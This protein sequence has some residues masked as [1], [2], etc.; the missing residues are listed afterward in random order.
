MTSRGW[1]PVVGAALLGAILGWWFGRQSSDRPGYE[2]IAGAEGGSAS[3][4]IAALTRRTQDLEK[5]LEAALSAASPVPHLAVAPTQDG[6]PGPQEAPPGRPKKLEEKQSEGVTVREVAPGFWVRV[7]QGAGAPLALE[8]FQ[9]A[10]KEP[11]EPAPSPGEVERMLDSRDDAERE[12]GYLALV[13]TNDK[14]YLP[15]LTRRVN[16][17]DLAPG[18][19]GDLMRSIARV[20]D[21]PWSAEQ[22]TGAPDTP[23][24][25]DNP[26]AWAS[27]REDMGE[28]TLELEFGTAVRVDA[29]RI[30]ETFN[31]GAVARVLAQ[32]PDGTWE[33]IWSGFAPV[34]D[35]PTWFDPSVAGTSYR[36]SRIR[37][38][39]DT[40]RVKGWNEIDAVELVGDGSRQ[41]VK[42][43]SASSSYAEP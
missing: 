34:V 12:K 6:E 7:G 18:K 2:G 29:V 43:A 30:H 9:P 19:A 13:T 42:A 10:T 17:P 21:R 25:G 28:V 35:A 11:Q 15:L 24:G 31:P 23:I 32:T 4:E 22:L 38:V 8:L 37:L 27:K 41:W 36:T 1:V 5:Q 20:K 26:S 39:L 16:D 14:A 33:Q 3:S 40:D